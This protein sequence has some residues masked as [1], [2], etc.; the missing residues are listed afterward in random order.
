[1][2]GKMD[3]INAPEAFAECTEKKRR[4][5]LEWIAESL[6]PASRGYRT[7]SY[8]LKHSFSAE[9]GLYVTNGEFKGAMLA[10]GYAPIHKGE[11]NWRFRCRATRKLTTAA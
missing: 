8:A 6:V 3:Q 5:L 9:A 10:A 1:M 11:L 4:R 2:T 7:T